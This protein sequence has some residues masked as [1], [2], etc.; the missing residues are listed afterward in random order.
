MI[1][2]F[3]DHLS[4]YFVYKAVPHFHV[5]NF[6]LLEILLDPLILLPVLIWKD[7]RRFS[8]H[9]TCKCLKRISLLRTYEAPAAYGNREK[10][11]LLPMGVYSGIRC[12]GARYV[13]NQALLIWAVELDVLKFLLQDRSK[14]L[15]IE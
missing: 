9:Y 11:S 15:V 14:H 12:F 4:F 6:P 13:K 7:S 8:H 2:S 3:L 1:H 10:V 5:C